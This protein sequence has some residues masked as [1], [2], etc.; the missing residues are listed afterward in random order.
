MRLRGGVGVKGMSFRAER[1]GGWGCF[2]KK[3]RGT[4]IVARV[5]VRE[6]LAN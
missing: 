2:G 1:L 3:E 5:P 6:M 4:L